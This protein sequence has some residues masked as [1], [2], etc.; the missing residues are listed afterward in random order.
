MKLIL[1][2]AIRAKLAHKTPPVTEDQARECFANRD[3]Q[4]LIDTRESNLTNP[5]TRWF[6]AETDFGVTL[7]VVFIPTGA[8][9]IVKSAYTP[10]AEE[11]RIYHKYG[12]Q[13]PI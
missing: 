3:G 11:T 8:G 13:E 1:S 5:L 10:K 4:F 6:I 9:I 7:K 2:L 12:H